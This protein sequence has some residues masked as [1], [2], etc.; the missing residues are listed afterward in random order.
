MN[1]RGGGAWHP[2]GVSVPP[3]TTAQGREDAIALV[4]VDGASRALAERAVAEAQAY[5]ATGIEERE[6]EG[7]RIA[8]LIYA[9][10][11]AAP[12]LRAAVAA[13]LGAGARVGAVEPVPQQDWTGAWREGLE[14]VLVSPRL[15]VRPSFV[16]AADVAA[17]H[18]LVIDPGQAFGTGHHASTRLALSLLDDVLASTRRGARVLDVGTGTGVLALAALALGAACAVALD[19][20]PL[21]AR[22]ARANARANALLERLHVFAGSVAALRDERFDLIAANLL[23]RELLPLVA[24]LAGRLAPGGALVLSGLLESER[25]A[26]QEALAPAGLVVVEERSEVDGGERWVGLLARPAGGA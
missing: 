8:L 18:V 9:P 16:D 1:A 17:E 5:G 22:E 6:G 19:S 23:R 13:A 10:A 15:A 7:G 3:G 20:D 24:D 11:A 21:A 26:V 14:P 12:A 2:A 25:E 4:R